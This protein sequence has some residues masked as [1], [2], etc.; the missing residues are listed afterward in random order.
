VVAS[1]GL[2]VTYRRSGG[3]A[4]IDMAAECLGPDLPEDQAQ[5]ASDLLGEPTSASTHGEEAKA[6]PPAA[7]SP[8]PGADQFTYT[9]RIRDGARSRT[10]TWSEGTVPD[11]ARPLLDTLAGLSAPSP[12]N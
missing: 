2:H 4:G 6:D 10:F 5:A 1:E 3:F 11:V 7:S 12:V 8:G 9:V